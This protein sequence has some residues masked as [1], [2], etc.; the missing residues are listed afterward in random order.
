MADGKIVRK[1]G[2][3]GTKAPS[4]NIVDI[5]F[6][7]VTFTITNNDTATADIFWEVGDTTPEANTL[8]L[9]GGA[10][11]S[12][13]VVTGLTAETSYTI[14]AFANVEGKVGSVTTILTF[15]TGAIPIWYGDRALFMGGT[16]P[17]AT[18]IIEYVTISTPGN[19]TDFGDLTRSKYQ[20]GAC[21]N[22]TRGVYAGGYDNPNTEIQYV[23]ISTP[24][25][26]TYFGDLTPYGK[27]QIS[28]C[29][30]GVRGLFSGD[31]TNWGPASNV[32]YITVAT[33]GNAVYFGD[34]QYRPR[35]PGAL[36]NLTRAV[37]AGGLYRAVNIINYV[38]VATLGNGVDFGDLTV[39]REWLTGVSSETRGI[40]AGGV[41]NSWYNTIDYITIATPGNAIDFGDLTVAR[42]ELGGSAN[43]TR[44]VF[45]GGYTGSGSGVNTIDYVTI[46]TP[47]N[48]TDFGD[49][50]ASRRTVTSCSGN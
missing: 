42:S 15:T 50:S 14:F 30:N 3:V 45:G 19:V 18:N 37:F 49:L 25:N 48:A 38:T 22:G 35:S 7:N 39:A 23:T 9:A 20:G 10:T 40:F 11:S 34:L 17:A 33:L 4:I 1:G 47:G 46:A 8:S 36:A 41:D 16:Q 12:N 27:Y 21:S 28:G 43:G 2:A 5:G 6:D 13:Q 32:L 24:G 44:A 31:A 29:S 26:A